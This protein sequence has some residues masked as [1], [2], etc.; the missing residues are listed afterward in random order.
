M[1]SIRPTWLPA[2]RSEMHRL[3]EIWR[4]V[5]PRATRTVTSRS[6]AV[7]SSACRCRDTGVV[8]GSDPSFDR[9]YSAARSNDIACPSVS[10]TSHAVSPNRERSGPRS[11]PSCNRHIIATGRASCTL[12][13]VEILHPNSGPEPSD[14]AKALVLSRETR[15]ILL[16]RMHA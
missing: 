15:V 9:A 16:R 2:V 8:G 13:G 7:S 1:P 5:R 6:R 14:G 12:S 4:L 10:A 3:V 11:P